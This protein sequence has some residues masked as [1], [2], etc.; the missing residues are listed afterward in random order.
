MEPALGKVYIVGGLHFGDE[1]KGTTVDY[2]VKEVDAKAVVRF[3]GGPQ[4]AHHVVTS[5]GVWHC[6]SHYGSGM[7]QEKC[8][9]V[10]SRLMLVYPQTLV[11]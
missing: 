6:F 8:V 10:L 11:N 1:G 7:L 4:A 3:G 2:L 9:T 5:S